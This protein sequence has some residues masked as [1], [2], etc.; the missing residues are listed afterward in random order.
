MRSFI[1]GVLAIVSLSLTL[2]VPHNVSAAKGKFPS[3]TIT[4][5]V[6]ANPGGGFDLHS[7]AVAR[8]M[9]EKLGVNI[10]VKNVPG[11]GGTIS[12]NL[13]WAAKPDGYT[14]GIVNLPGGIISEL[15]RT[16][17]YRLRGFTW[18]GRIS[19]APYVWAVGKQYPFRSLKDFQNAKE[20]LIPNSGVGATSWVNAAL[21]AATMKF[22]PKFIS[23]YRGA[24]AANMAVV[25]GEGEARPLGLDSPGQMAFVKDG[26]MVPLWVYLKKRDPNYPDV[27]TV[28][29]LGY[30]KLA[31]LAAN[32]V[33]AAP[34]G[35]PKDRLAILIN[36]FKEAIEDPKT[37]EAF[38]GM[39]A[40]TSPIYGKA[41]LPEMEVMFELIEENA[42]VFRKA[43]K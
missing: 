22:K 34:P 28:G 35:V 9:R 15:F 37:Q 25:R 10:I 41:W 16:T 42:E 8:V 4:W 2:A 33:V 26:S 18:I 1:C 6:N 7:R 40:K 5:L 24:P 12:W 27:P 23:G 30:P 19:A 29:E 14:V 39:K 3:R 32:R 31:V 11:A 13:L 36:A 20:V 17:Q 43:L 21:T 38:K